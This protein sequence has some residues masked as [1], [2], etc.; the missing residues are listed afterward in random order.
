[1]T[2]HE[3]MTRILAHK[4][5]DRV[6]ITDS[7]WGPTLD[8]WHREGLPKGIAWDRHFAL[9]RFASIGVDNSP[10]FPG[11]KI[12]ETEEWVIT[13]TNWG[14][15][16][17]NWKKH[18]GVPEFIDFEV[19]DRDSWAKARAR[20]TPTRDRIDFGYLQ[21]NYANWRK[22]GAWIQA[23]F[24]FGFDITHSWFLGTDKVLMAMVEDPEWII[25]VMNH[26]LDLNI[27][28]YEMVWDAGYHFDAISWPDD[29]G[30]KG[31][32][33][34]SL[35]MYR[36]ILKPIHKRATDWAHSKGAKVHLHSC[37]DVR[38]FIPDL[39]EIGI[40]MLNPLEVK[41][42]MDPAWLKRMYG[43]Q[44]TFHGGL[45]AALFWD[46][47]KMEEHMRQVIPAMKQDGGY[48]L[49]SDHSVPDSVSF[50]QFG[51]FVELAKALGRY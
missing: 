8:R 34:F 36:E 29:M 2:T 12:E 25:E 22:Q 33:F 49:S 11:R 16:I 44:L 45:N 51:R 6:P 43:K 17:K 13:Y 32:T 14:A 27:A 42:G 4:E 30:Y 48:I 46:M 40:D 19:K 38:S 10:R 3:R 37:G 9:D 20:M 28:L 1:M 21:A 15:T 31:K 41:A 39:I 18:G 35:D 26:E 23:G 7:P 47:A 24:W 5:A 50:E